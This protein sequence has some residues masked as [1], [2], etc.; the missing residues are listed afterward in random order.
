LAFFQETGNQKPRGTKGTKTE[1]E[2][3]GDGLFFLGKALKSIVTVITGV[4]RAARR[5]GI[6]KKNQGVSPWSLSVSYLS[7]L[8]DSSPWK[9]KSS[10][11]SSEWMKI[12]RPPSLFGIDP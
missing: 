6:Q 7:L 3:Q 5:V 10:I 1:P 11:S 12:M 8:D 4:S 2:N 9:M